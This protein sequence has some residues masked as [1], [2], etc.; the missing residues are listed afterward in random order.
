MKKKELLPVI[1]DNEVS[2]LNFLDMSVSYQIMNISECL[3]GY[4]YVSEE[5]RNIISKQSKIIDKKKRSLGITEEMESIIKIDILNSILGAL[6]TKNVE[7]DNLNEKLKKEYDN[8]SES[9]KNIIIDL[10][11]EKKEI[12]QGQLAKKLGCSSAF[13]TK[14]F[15]DGRLNSFVKVYKLNERNV[16]YSLKE[17]AIEYLNQNNK[18]EIKYSFET[19]PTFKNIIGRKKQS[20]FNIDKKEERMPKNWIAL[21]N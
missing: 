17:D 5:T 12:K 9:Y 13:I 3:S 21:K 6:S 11:N 7:T 8:M 1:V 10:Y 14:Q 4:A 15:K 19:I 18:K 2:N 20:N 16:F